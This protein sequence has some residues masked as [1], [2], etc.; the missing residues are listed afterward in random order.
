MNQQQQQPQTVDVVFVEAEDFRGINP[1]LY[2]DYLIKA[3]LRDNRLDQNAFVNDVNALELL[4]SNEI[5]EQENFESIL[6]KDFKDADTDS[7]SPLTIYH[8][9]FMKFKRLIELVRKRS[10]KEEAL[11]F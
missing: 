3:A 9:A 11:E 7:K 1:E 4:L 8:L 6:E 5:K 10:I 2:I